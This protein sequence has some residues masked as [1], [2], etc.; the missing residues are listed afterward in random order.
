MKA[1]TIPFHKTQ[2]KVL[3]ILLFNANTGLALATMTDGS[4]CVAH[5]MRAGCTPPGV[6]YS[7]RSVD[8]AR[9]AYNRHLEGK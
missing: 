4:F 5:E 9:R 7:G 3:Q 8:A 6:I 2:S 1:G